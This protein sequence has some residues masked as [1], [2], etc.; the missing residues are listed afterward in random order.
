E[1]EV[2]NVVDDDL[3][4]SRAF[5]R[6]YKAN[7]RS[8]PSL[9]VPYRMF[10]LFSYLWERY[11]DRSNR[12]LPLAFNTLK[13]AAEW[14]RQRYSNEKLKQRLAWTPRVSTAEGLKRHF[15]YFR[16]LERVNA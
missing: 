5:L 7:V 12:Q 13:S 2:F 3:P 16:G 1:G 4:T 10:Y 11:S 9:F 8:F 14:K 6:M 15:E